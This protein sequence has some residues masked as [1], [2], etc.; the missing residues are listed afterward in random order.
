MVCTP[1]LTRRIRRTLFNLFRAATTTTTIATPT[2]ANSTTVAPLRAGVF[3]GGVNTSSFEGAVE[4]RLVE[5]VEQYWITPFLNG[6]Y[7]HEIET[8]PFT[9]HVTQVLHFH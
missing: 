1:A 6:T 5:K 7:R 3:H 2:T 9:L 8:S 4:C